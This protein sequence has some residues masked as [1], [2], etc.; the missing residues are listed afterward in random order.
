MRDRAEKEQ[1]IFGHLE[2]RRR[3]NTIRIQ[4]HNEHQSQKQEIRQDVQTYKGMLSGLREK[5]LEEYSRERQSRG[6]S[7]DPQNKNRG[8]SFE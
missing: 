6:V 2:Q 7:K 8:R 3:L 5:R 4:E 1:L